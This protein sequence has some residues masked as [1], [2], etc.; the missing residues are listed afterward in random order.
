MEKY[1]YITLDIMNEWEAYI[2]LN[3][4]IDPNKDKQ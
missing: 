4:R 3:S 1:G 2:A